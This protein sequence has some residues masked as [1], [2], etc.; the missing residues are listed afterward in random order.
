[1]LLYI[2]D[3]ES[4]NVRLTW[5]AHEYEWKERSVDWF[6]TVGLVG[7]AGLVLAILVHDTLFGILIFC[8]FGFLAYL[9]IRKPDVLTVT[10]TDTSIIIGENVM[11]FKTLKQFYVTSD[12]NTP[13]LL[14]M[15]NRFFIPMT[16]VPLENVDPSEVREVLLQSVEEKEMEESRSHKLLERIGL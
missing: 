9:S 7:V 16:S 6:W 10:L 3:M 11:P 5:Q 14:L 2:L 12:T 1:M 13:S 8:S 4:E 15:T